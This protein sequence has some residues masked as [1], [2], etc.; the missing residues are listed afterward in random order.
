MYNRR[1]NLEDN[2]TPTQ[3][4]YSTENP[5]YSHFFENLD[6]DKDNK[7]VN[8]LR[9]K[10]LKLFPI[11]SRVRLLTTK[12]AFAKDSTS[13]KYTTKVFY[14]SKIKLPIISKFQVRFIVKDEKGDELRGLFLPYELKRI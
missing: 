2:L 9:K 4:I 12:K 14:I 13:E 7:K 1:I 5:K 6:L 11:N 8:D 3:R 10:W